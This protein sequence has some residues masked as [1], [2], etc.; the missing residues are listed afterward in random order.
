MLL[1]VEIHGNYH[2]IDGYNNIN[3]YPLPIAPLF[4]CIKV[5]KTMIHTK[6]N[7]VLSQN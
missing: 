7:T 6:L 5:K 3:V 4:M 2:S 1:R